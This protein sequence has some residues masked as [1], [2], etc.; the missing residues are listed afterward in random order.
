MLLIAKDSP[1]VLVEHGDGCTLLNGCR[2]SILNPLDLLAEGAVD[3]GQSLIDGGVGACDQPTQS[4]ICVNNQLSQTLIN[5]GDLRA[6]TT[7]T[8]AN[9]TLSRHAF[10]PSKRTV[11]AWWTGALR[12][13][14]DE[15][16]WTYLHLQRDVV[17]AVVRLVRV[18]RE[19]D[20][21]HRIGRA[22]GDRA[23]VQQDHIG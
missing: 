19:G 4:C 20:G 12:H 13:A 3:V 5:V 9:E 6:K 22:A 21:P 23:R 14:S 1:V 2:E 7:I 18:E 15:T 16:E 17:D 10:A 8:K 11:R